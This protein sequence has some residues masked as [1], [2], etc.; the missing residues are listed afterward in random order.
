[1]KNLTLTRLPIVACVGL[2]LTLFLVNLWNFA[3]G[4]DW[5]KLRI[6]S[7]EPL[8]GVPG[9]KPVPWS[10]DAF[11]RG[12]AQKA[13]S[14]SLGQTM[15]VFPIAVRAKSQFLYSLFSASGAPGVIVGKD[16]QLFEKHYVRE[17]C[18]RGGAPDPEAVDAWADRVRGVQKAVEAKGKGF[19]Y[20]IS[21][22]KAAHLSRFLPADLY[23]ASVANGMM[24]K[25]A[26][27]RATLDAR[28]VVYVDGAS[29][30]TAAAP[31]YPIGLFPRGGTH[32]N[33]LGSAIA[34]RALT[35]A[36]GRDGDAPAL[37]PYDFDWRERREEARGV[38]RDLL[39]LLNLLW[40]DAN[41]PTAEIIGRNAGGCAGTPKLFAVGG[42]FLVQIVA[43]LVESPC[44]A[45]VDYWHYVPTAPEP[46]GRFLV[47]KQ[48][49]VAEFR[50]QS[51][52]TADD[53]AMALAD[54][55]IVLLEENESVIANMAQVSDLLAAA[56][57]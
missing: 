46:F 16:K 7:A 40:P 52:K 29:L 33:S 56:S 53:F 11:L 2:I 39:N 6:R 17:F 35:R 27:F 12:E 57:K 1:M 20:L 26:S 54:A 10:L 8:F 44:G 15:P 55:Q 31:D 49:G 9:P 43:N 19:V 47:R 5:P 45:N 4:R 38:D 24:E 13:F 41:Y 36:L 28:G 50:A 21:P 37:P 25:L 32:W 14:T 34:A 18:E 30:M 22:S 23:C 48:G 42:S 3:V 51:S